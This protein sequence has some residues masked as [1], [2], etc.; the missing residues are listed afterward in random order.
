MSDELFQFLI[1]LGLLVFLY[2]PIY[3]W[4]NC[5]PRAL[6]N[7]AFEAA[8]AGDTRDA[9]LLLDRLLAGWKK[10]PE[11]WFSPMSLACSMIILACE[12]EH[13]ETAQAVL[14]RVGCTA[15]ELLWEEEGQAAIPLL[16]YV[17]ANPDFVNTRLFLKHAP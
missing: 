1:F 14:A 13:P 10:K 15:S 12:W 6:K 4:Q 11:T 2:P 3:Y 5:T 8:E 17:Q 7:R 9:L 16:E